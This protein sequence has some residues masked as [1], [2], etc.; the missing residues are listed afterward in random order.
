MLAALLFTGG[1]YWRGV[2]RLRR[3]TGSGPKLSSA[4]WCFAAGWLALAIALVSPLH[5]WGQVLF[6]VHMTQHEVLMLLAAPLLILGRPGLVMLWA[7]PRDSAREVAR[8]TR[9]PVVRKAIAVL[10]LP[11]AAWTLH[12]MALWAWH[13]PS[14]FEATLR[15]GWI[16]DLQHASFFFTALI[17]WHALFH[18]P[19]RK[20]GY[21]AGVLY[22]FT[23]AVHSGALG[24][25]ITFGRRVWY[26]HYVLSA[27]TV[28]VSPLNDQQL[29]GLIMWIPASFVYVV[30]AL[31]MFKSWLVESDLRV[32]TEMAPQSRA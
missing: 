14:W 16:H 21:G 8:W 7:L 24:A 9:W 1:M 19:R 29:G 17:F 22:L 31:I 26:P 20:R 30:A 11:F 4:A 25:L 32:P 3:A 13:I 28:G 15:N 2:Q 10:T 12:A 27:P 6:S 23:T 18:G 5:P